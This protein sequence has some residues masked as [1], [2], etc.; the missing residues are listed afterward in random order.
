MPTCRHFA[1]RLEAV[2]MK[3]LILEDDKETADHLSRVLRAQGH[4][5]DLATNGRDA[6]IMGTTSH[7]D[8][9]ILDRMVPALDGLSV[10]RTLRSAGVQ[11]PALFLSAVGGVRDRVDGLQAGADD[12]LVKPFASMELIARVE[13]LG[14][15]RPTTVVE[16]VLKV[17]DLELDM[18]RRTVVRAGRKII[19]QPQEFKLLEYMM[20]HAEQIVT[21]TM[22]LENVW[23]FHFD[24]G[25][26]IIESHISRLRT[27]VDKGFDRELIK[28]IRKVGYRIENAG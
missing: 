22:L 16:T 17:G 8:V 27:K 2:P 7:H 6:V 14:R 13:A 25:T 23:D 26:N 15:R 20:R 18:L 24:P 3:I 21:R 28:T 19:L 12:Y 10:L 1:R 5:V 9:L 11:S 4:V